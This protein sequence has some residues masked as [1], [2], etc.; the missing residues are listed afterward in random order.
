MD[1]KTRIKH[2]TGVLEKIR[3]LCNL[4][5]GEYPKVTETIGPEQHRLDLKHRLEQERPIKEGF[6]YSFTA[7]VNASTDYER[8]ND[9]DIIR[10]LWRE[11]SANK[12]PDPL[13]NA[14]L[15]YCKEVE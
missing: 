7:L 4:E 2:L 12:L 3:V 15:E 13:V 8:E 6:W 1:D 11:V 5:L 9:G 14:F 10:Y